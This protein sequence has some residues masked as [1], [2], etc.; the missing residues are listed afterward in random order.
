MEKLKLDDRFIVS[1]GNGKPKIL[2]EKPFKAFGLYCNFNISYGLVSNILAYKIS[3]AEVYT[4]SIDEVEIGQYK[5]FIGGQYF[6]Y[7]IRFKHS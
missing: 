1:K 4:K 6:L 2:P 5:F 7:F 3:A